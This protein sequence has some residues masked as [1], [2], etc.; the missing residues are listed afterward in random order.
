MANGA[1]ELNWD[2]I[3]AKAIA[4]QRPPEWPTDVRAISIEGLSL[5]GL[6]SRYQLHFDGK[7]LLIEKRLDLT[8]WQTLLAAMASVSA[9]IIA[10]IEVLRFCGYGA[11]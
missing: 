9:L 5:F 11:S 4:G 1:S 3:R 2:D 8:W 7:R 6:D 10:A